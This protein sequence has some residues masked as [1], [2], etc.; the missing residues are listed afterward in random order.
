MTESLAHAD[1][2]RDIQ[3]GRV[4]QKFIQGEPRVR[5][6]RVFSIVVSSDG[7]PLI[8]SRKF[9]IWPLMSFLVELPPQP[10]YKFEN[11]LLTGLWYGQSKP[12]VP[13]FLQH[14]TS[15]LSYLTH[16][17]EFED[18][19]GNSIPVVPDLPAKSLLFNIKQFN[20]QFGCSTCT[21]P[22]RFD[23]QLHARLYEYTTSSTVVIRTAHNTRRFAKL[24][25][26][27]VPQ[28]L[29]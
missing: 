19:T 28:F 14:F 2:I 16:G 27:Q 25:S 13:L 7:A 12:N 9:S 21:H 22:G 17:C 20:G 26:Q 15:E 3:D 11:I 8:K 18:V 1:Y 10:R 6:R 23:N 5:G 4:Y 24:L 29:A